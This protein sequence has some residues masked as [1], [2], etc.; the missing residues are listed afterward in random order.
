MKKKLREYQIQNIKDIFNEFKKGNRRVIYQ[1]GT[2]GGKTLTACELIHFFVE[3]NKP[4]EALFFVHRVELLQQFK[5]SFESQFNDFEVGIIDAK[6][7]MKRFD[8][9]VNVAMVETGYKRLKKDSSFFG[10][11]IK[12]VIMDE[13]HNSNFDKVLDFFPDAF[14]IGLTATPIRQSKKNPLNLHYNSIVCG[15]T[16]QELIDNDY[17]SPNLTYVIDNKINYSNLKKHAGDYSSTS[18][19]NELKNEKYVQNVIKVYIEKSLNKK[20]IV[21]NSNVDHSKLLTDAFIKAGFD[22]KHLDGTMKEDERISVLKWFEITPNA[23]LNNVAVLTAGYDEP[24]I[25]TVIFNLPTTSLSKWLQC[26]GRGSRKSHGKDFFTIIDLGNNAE[27]LGDWSFPHDWK[28][29]FETAKYQLSG[30]GEAPIKIC[31]ACAC[32]VHISVMECPA[33]G[34]EFTKKEE[35]KDE[36]E[37]IKVKL[38]V[39]N[40]AK[41]INVHKISNFVEKAGWKDY[42]GLYLIR[43]ILRK[44]LKEGNISE[45]SL[46]YEK[47]KS[48]YFDEV[49]KWCEINGKKFDN[50]HKDFAERIINE[51][52][53]QK[54]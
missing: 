11:K 43:D 26:C 20:T 19:F 36:E 16:I 54:V 9:S 12:L 28:E 53:K 32:A 13:A 34:F 33:C 48:I 51:N 23:I 1:L 41:K 4:F 45:G 15:P 5:R 6:S 29:I 49:A 3:K 42:A 22:A 35:E 27:R 18:I 39:N 44:D 10:N 7:R 24:T 17:L 2:G 25:E 30:E 21:F 47:L 14:V 46:E 50:W 40:F 8:L 37:E 31:P 52:E 38:L